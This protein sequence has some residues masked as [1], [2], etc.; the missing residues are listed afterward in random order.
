[1]PSTS[2]LIGSGNS[3]MCTRSAGRPEAPLVAVSLPNAPRRTFAA[4]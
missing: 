1:V 4:V 3:R 2:T